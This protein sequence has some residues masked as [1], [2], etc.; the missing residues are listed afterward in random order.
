VKKKPTSPVVDPSA[1]VTN[2]RAAAVM[3]DCGKDR[4]Y[5]LLQAKEIE[6]YRDGEAR[7]II[8]ASVKNYIARK[9]AESKSGFE[10][11]RYPR[12][13]APS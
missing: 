6:S 4:V 8:V 1:L 3:L 2:V 5:A 9:L 10:R 11:S 12:K 7:R 13:P